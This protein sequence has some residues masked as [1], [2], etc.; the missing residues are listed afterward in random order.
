MPS[1]PLLLVTCLLGAGCA[2]AWLRRRPR[3]RSFVEIAPA[4]RRF[5]HDQGLVEA[6]DFLA[7]PALIVSGHLD[8]HVARAR[9]GDGPGVVF[10]YLKREHRVPWSV[11]LRN[12]LAGFGLASRS[13]REM[14]VLQALGRE[15]FGAPELLAAGEDDQ[16]RAFLL[17]REVEGA[18]DLRSFLHEEKDPQRRLIVIGRLAEMLARLHDA[19]FEHPD[20]YAKHVLVSPGPG[21]V[22]LLD[23]QRARRRRGLGWRAR[24]RGLAAL[25]ATLGAGLVNLRER[26]AFLRAYLDGAQQ[27]PEEAEVVGRPKPPPAPRRA[28]RL[29]L[30]LQGL[31]AR[32]QRLSARRHV[33]EKQQ[34]PGPMQAWECVDG[35]A[36]CVSPAF[37]E[38]YPGPMPPWLKTPSPPPPFLQGAEGGNARRWLDETGGRLVLVRRQARALGAM[39]WARLR[40]RPFVSP[41]Q[42]LAA[43]LLRLERHAVGAPRV[44][45]LGQRR[46]R[47][48]RVESFLLT[49]PPADAVSLSAW[50]RLPVGCC[51]PLRQE[52]LRGAGALLARIHQAACHLAGPDATAELCVNTRPGGQAEVVLGAA[53]AL[54][55]LRRRSGLRQ[56]R[57]LRQVLRHLATA[58]CRR[59]ELRLFG[60][61]YQAAMNQGEAQRSLSNSTSRTAVL[62]APPRAVVNASLLPG[63]PAPEHLSAPGPATEAAAPGRA[64]RETWWRRLVHGVRR[65][66]QRSDWSLYV[67]D[68]WPQRILEV[69]VTDNFHAKQGRS[70]GRWVLP[71][72]PGARLLTVYLKRHYKLPWWQGLLAWLF[73]GQGWS[74]ALQE[75]RH[76]EWARRQ[77]MPVPP[78]VAA[79]EFIGPGLRFQSVLAVEE[80]TDMLPLHEAVPLAAARQAPADFRRWKRGL[81]AEMARL[82]RMLH[83]RRVFH[84][85]FYLCHFFIH[86]AHTA[87]APEGGWQGQVYLIDLHRLGHHPWTW[88][89]F[90]LKD[91]AQLLYSSE[92]QGIDIRDRLWFWHAYNGT[93]RR[94]AGRWLRRWIW[95]KWQ[96]YRRHNARQKVRAAR[97]AA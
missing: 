30:V 46:G 90:Q 85:D 65:V 49:Q 38:L 3:R 53:E 40:G 44:L 21:Q 10:A 15:A 71:A 87:M 43:L 64:T 45:A 92:V 91:L 7:L 51:R 27:H 25:E 75:W 76:L 6:E 52:V 41:E 54:V 31:R 88:R 70:T 72:P 69:A 56:R 66:R 47:R 26:L 86:R 73:P 58:G 33:Q 11:R 81:A 2:A 13:L 94:G 9:L 36:L 97:R 74:P 93:G 62:D 20:L 89:W 63:P 84:K 17:V 37:R 48:G 55:A 18:L 22:Y 35:E 14:K 79:A 78:V 29:R 32:G 60:A 23:W 42:R 34:L 8:R 24:G 4:W 80:L 96:R 5:L 68:D 57:D 19:G 82:A 83:D 67:G 16:G 28:A 1:L 50:L 59:T 77:G 39:L 61:A 95:L 12:L